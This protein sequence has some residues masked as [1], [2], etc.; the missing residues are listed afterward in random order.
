[1]SEIKPATPLP[2]LQTGRINGSPHAIQYIN[3]GGIV[4]DAAFCANEEIATA[5]VHACNAYP[6]LVALVEA[7]S[8]EYGHGSFKTLLRELG[9]AK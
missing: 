7:W 9:E 8:W 1:M 3:N 6:K 4:A 2:Q 5:I